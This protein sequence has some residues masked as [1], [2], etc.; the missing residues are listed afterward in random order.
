M[1]ALTPPF[2][3]STA[4]PSP[5]GSQ[6]VPDEFEVAYGEK[7]HRMLDLDTWTSGEDLISAYGRLE[8]EVSQAAASESEI[9]KKVRQV[10]FDRLRTHSDLPGVAGLYE[11]QLGDLKKIHTGLLFNGGVEACDGTCVVHDTLPLTIT[12]IGVCLVSYNG[13]QGAWMN[14]LYRRDFRERSNESIEDVVMAVLERREKREAQGLGGEPMSELARR[15]LMAY[16]ERA[17]LREKSKACWR[18]GHGNPAPYELLTGKWASQKEAIRR[19]LGLIEWYVLEHKRFVYVPSAPRERHFLTIGNALRPREFAII[20]S[21]K[22]NIELMLDR[23][24]YRESSGVRPLMEKFRDEVAPKIAVGL[25]RAS[26]AA[27]AYLFY[28]QVD[29]IEMAA[30]IAIA[31]SLLQEHRGFPVL[32]DLADR[33]CRSTFDA[34]SFKSSAQ[35]AYARTGQPF[36]YLSERETR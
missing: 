20:G 19:S 1:S 15:G 36:R 27:P 16:A 21:M 28:A 31:D 25:Y 2:S 17:V 5:P 3:S 11:A 23:G 14:R 8:A 10:V 32:I 9:T 30:H 34:E 6:I 4:A 26:T 29:H 18:M 35:T 12:Q 22:A 13:Q 33:V 24:G 7:L